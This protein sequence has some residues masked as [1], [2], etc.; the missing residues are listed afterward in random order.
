[1]LTFYCP[2]R[3]WLLTLVLATGA[4][5]A[6]YPGPAAPQDDSPFGAKLQRAM[7]LMATSTPQQRHKVKV[8]FYGQSITVQKWWRAVADDLHRRFP[9]ADLEIKNKAIGG[10]SS[11][12]LVRIAEHDLYTYYPDLLI[13]HVYGDHRRYEDIIRRTRQ[14]TTADI[15]I[16][17]DHLAAREKPNEQGEYVDQGWTA[18]MAEWLLD[19]ARKYDCE[20]INIRPEW[21]RYLQDNNLTPPDLLR[22]GVH[23]NDHGCF[24]LAELIKRHLVHR[25]ELAREPDN[26]V[27]TYVVGRDI[28]WND[29]KLTLEFT[30]NRVDAIAARPNGTPGTAKVLIDGKRPS[31]FPQA[32]AV[33]R[34]SAIHNIW[35]AVIQV[36]WEKPPV[37]EDWTCRILESDEMGSEFTFEVIGS[38]TG[39]DGRGTSGERFVS[40]SGRVVIDPKDWHMERTC[41]HARKPV[42]DGLEIRWEVVPM[43]VDRYEPPD[44]E[45][46]AREYTTTLVQGIANEPHELELRAVQGAPIPIRAIRVYRPPFP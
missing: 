35:P 33:T 20:I 44:V 40:D 41:R 2:G 11:Q 46:P 21:K 42:P 43:F 14:R 4:R 5:A 29:G 10:F 27:T 37:V 15:A 3:L 28:D 22:D 31:E 32:Y 8:L 34:P 18:F 1:M 45:D 25:P 13:F 24:L 16:Y 12:Y 7:G 17:T 6:S 26:R 30:G 38:R 19:N 39:R 36:S 23:L 9:H